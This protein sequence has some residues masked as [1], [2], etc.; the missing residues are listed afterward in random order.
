MSLFGRNHDFKHLLEVEKA[1]KKEYET[2]L[3]AGIAKAKKEYD[4]DLAKLRVQFSRSDRKGIVN[5]DGSVDD[6]LRSGLEDIS[7]WCK[8]MVAV[9]GIPDATTFASH[10]T[11]LDLLKA[12]MEVYIKPDSE[13]HNS[14]SKI[15]DETRSLLMQVFGRLKN[16]SV[17]K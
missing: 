14:F 11:R 2:Q 9:D 3:Y 13:E 17:S 8:G 10:A 5:L 16:A 6:L 1:L 4:D 15:F 12:L 7:V